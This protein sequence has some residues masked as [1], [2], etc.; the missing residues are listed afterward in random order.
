MRRR[1]PTANELDADA[2]PLCICADCIRVGG[3]AR[4]REAERQRAALQR[5]M[6]R[7]EEYRERLRVVARQARA[8]RAV[9][10]AS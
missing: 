5:Q 9:E 1:I 2:R 8:R 10:A 7:G 4:Q 6:D 3:P